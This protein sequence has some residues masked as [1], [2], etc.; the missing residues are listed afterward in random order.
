MVSLS[1]LFQHTAARRRLGSAAVEQRGTQRFQHTAAR[2]RLGSAEQVRLPH[3]RFQHTAAR[4]RL[5]PLSPMWAR[6]WSFNTQPPEGG[7]LAHQQRQPALPA[8]FNTQPPEGGWCRLSYWRLQTQVSTHSRPKA[9]G[10]GG[11]RDDAG[12]VVST[13]SRPKAAGRPL[14]RLKPPQ[15]VSTHS[16]PKAAGRIA[17]V[18]PD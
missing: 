2:R 10:F 17:V 11:G 7:W 4:R 5:G 1:Y 9:A 8:C 18:H 13:H 14:Q 16:R 12:G 15:M 6:W 3:T